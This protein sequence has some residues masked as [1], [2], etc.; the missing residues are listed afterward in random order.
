VAARNGF[1]AAT[2]YYGITDARSFAA[3]TH[4]FESRYADGLIGPL[5]G[6]DATY[7]ERSPAQQVTSKTCPILQLHGRDDPIVPPAQAHALAAQLT[8]KGVPHALLEFKEESHG[9]RR[10]ETII[11]A[12][13]AELSL[14]AQALNFPHPDTPMLR[15]HTTAPDLDPAPPSALEPP[16]ASPSPKQAS[17]APPAPREA[18]TQ[19]RASRA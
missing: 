13:E 3:T 2:S 16:L 5:P 7:A 18:V 19:E 12:I 6:F 9:F 14:Y 10:H 17:P 11:A 4:D 15:L 1:R 8:H